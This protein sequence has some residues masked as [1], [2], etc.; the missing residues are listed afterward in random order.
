MLVALSQP[1]G[2]GKAVDV[3]AGVVHVAHRS[4]DMLEPFKRELIGG[5]GR[6][7]AEPSTIQQNRAEYEA[8]SIDIAGQSLLQQFIGLRDGANL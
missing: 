3:F 7:L 1:F 6:N 2:D 4:E 5:E 8:L